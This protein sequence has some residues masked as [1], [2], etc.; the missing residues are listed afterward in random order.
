MASRNE[1]DNTENYIS[2]YYKGVLNFSANVPTNP[3]NE[4][5]HFS[6][7]ID[8]YLKRDQTQEMYIQMLETASDFL[9][10][11]AT[12]QREMVLEEAR[13]IL[14]PNLPSRK[15][16]I[17]LCDNK[18]IEFWKEELGNNSELF[19][20]S[21]TGKLFKS[22]DIFIP[23]DRMNILE[24]YER[25]KKYWNPDFSEIDES[26]TEYLFQGKIKVLEKIN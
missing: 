12:V 23:D 1:I 24:M 6:D 18:Q 20:V 2:S 9:K 21:V 17:W 8:D 4:M 22:S 3:D 15:N 10:R 16:S 5:V 26:K 13:K 14:Y 11:Y 25:A 7:I 19:R